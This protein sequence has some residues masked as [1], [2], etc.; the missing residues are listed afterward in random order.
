[1]GDYP[2]S[3]QRSLRLQAVVVAGLLVAGLGAFFYQLGEKKKADASFYAGHELALMTGDYVPL[4]DSVKALGV[5]LASDER[6]P[7]WLLALDARAEL[8][9]SLLYTGSLRQRQRSGELIELALE[10]AP[11]DVDVLLSQAL[12]EACLGNPSAA[13][14]S[15]DSGALGTIHP[16][17]A[18]VIRA[19]A[20]LRSGAEVDAKELVRSAGTD[21]GRVWALRVAWA[22][23][24]P[25][26]VGDV[27]A[28]VLSAAPSNPYAGT[29]SLLASVRLEPRGEAVE[30]LRGLL[31]GEVQ[32][33]AVLGSLVAVDLSRLMRREGQAKE[34]DQLLLELAD[35]DPESYVLQA[36]LARL[37]RFRAHFGVAFDRADKALRSNPGDA[38]LLAEMAAALWFRDSAAKI[39]SRLSLVPEALKETDGVRR[40]EAIAALLIGD[41]ERAIAGLEST[42]HLGQPGD[43]ELWLAHAQLEAGRPK[44]ALDE[45][46]SAVQ[47]L[48]LAYGEPSHAVTIARLYEGLAMQASGDRGAGGQILE[49]AYV[50][51]YQTPWAAWLYG[52]SLS[53]PAERRK[54]KDLYL[55]ACHHG[56]DFALP[57]WELSQIYQSMRLDT[58]EQSTLQRV[59]ELYL[60]RSPEGVHADQVR[61][62]LEG[63]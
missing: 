45:A 60:R 3:R 63:G 14:A 59:R 51:P 12:W 35:Q 19:E 44:E 47:L 33:P 16:T 15:L 24:D 30:Q 32:L 23:G 31:Q 54:A 52:R 37:E 53:E 50:A 39:E 2:N 27:A 55:L 43:V 8:V 6:A 36:E 13:L 20:K 4:R 61:K 17:W 34:A 18:A 62:A 40:G 41:T 57:C 48:G 46:R 26:V 22:Q 28:V 58:V 1:M 56:Q 11:Q 25:A 9:V 29:L 10:R 21:L 42:R 49:A 38:E 5:A 7:G